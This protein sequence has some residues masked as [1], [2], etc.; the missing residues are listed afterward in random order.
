MATF[1]YNSIT[2]PFVKLQGTKIL[3]SLEATYG[4]YNS[5]EDAYNSIKETFNNKA[6]IPLG[7]TVGIIEGNEITEYWFKKG[8]SSADDLKVKNSNSEGNQS[9]PAGSYTIHRIHD[10]SFEDSTTNLNATFSAA[11]GDHVINT[12][13]GAVYIKYGEEEWVK[14]NGTILTATASPISRIINAHVLSYK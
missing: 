3:P 6:E 1:D 10:A 2:K 4:P 5:K 13:T 14:L 8:T 11:V 9:T 7:L 12:A